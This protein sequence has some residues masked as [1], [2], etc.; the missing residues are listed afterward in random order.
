[1]LRTSATWEGGNGRVEAQT[2]QEAA[3]RQHGTVKAWLGV[4]GFGF[5]LLDSGGGE[6]F[7]HAS[8]IRRGSEP[9]PVVGDAVSFE[10]AQSS[11]GLRALGV[12]FDADGPK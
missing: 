7:F 3:T 4:K 12:T 1:M 9:A 8:A 5:L 11:K 2:A 6:V 10:V